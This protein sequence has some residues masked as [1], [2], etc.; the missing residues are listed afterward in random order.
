MSETACGSPVGPG[1]FTC[2]LRGCREALHVLA[3]AARA[4]DLDDVS[5]R[6]ISL[7]VALMGGTMTPRTAPPDESARP[8]SS[9]GQRLRLV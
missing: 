9:P 8:A 6:D 4:N 1:C 2:Q 5:G 7:M 3:A